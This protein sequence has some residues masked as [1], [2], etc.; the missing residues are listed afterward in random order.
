MSEIDLSRGLVAKFGSETVADGHGVIQEVINFQASQLNNLGCALIVV[1]SGAVLTGKAEAPE[2]DDEQVLAGL[3]S[4]TIGMAWKYGF[5]L[6]GRRAGLVLATDHEISDPG[7]GGTLKRALQKDLHYGV[8]PIFNTNDKLNIEELVKRAWKGENDGPAAHITVLMQ[9][10]ALCL[11]TKHNGLF[12]DSHNRN[13]IAE[14]PYNSQ[15]HQRILN[16]VAKRGEKGQGIYAKVFAAIEAARGGADAYIAGA[17]EDIE[18][19][20]K[21]QTGTHFVAKPVEWNRS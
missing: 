9:M 12:D 2:I 8:V 11:M 14:V 6:V 15:A 4:P 17:G 5:G 16:M 7:E 19:I 1:T 13:T 20:L 10:G 18:R 3:G 21:G